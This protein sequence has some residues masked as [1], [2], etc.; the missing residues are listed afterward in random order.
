MLSVIMLS[1]VAPPILSLQLLQVL[2]KWQV[3]KTAGH[4]KT[5]ITT[6]QISQPYSR[7]AWWH[8]FLS[9]KLERFGLKKSFTT[10]PYICAHCKCLWSIVVESS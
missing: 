9:N 1:V 5:N 8:K 4:Q 6:R 3:D 2:M 7:W 10:L